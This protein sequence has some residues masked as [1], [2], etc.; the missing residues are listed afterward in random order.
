MRREALGDQASG[1]RSRSTGGE[2]LE[3]PAHPARGGGL[4][5]FLTMPPHLRDGTEGQGGPQEKATAP[6]ACL[7]AISG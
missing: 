1:P 5:A 3:L 6:S 2:G 4:E 7:S